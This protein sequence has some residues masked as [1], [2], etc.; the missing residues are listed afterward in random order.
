M[1]RRVCMLAWAAACVRLH[2]HRDGGFVAGLEIESDARS[3]SATTGGCPVGAHVGGTQLYFG[4]L[5]P[6]WL[7]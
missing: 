4:G 1:C 5:H 3:T 2:V 6:E 7:M